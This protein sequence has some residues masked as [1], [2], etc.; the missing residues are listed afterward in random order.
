MDDLRALDFVAKSFAGLLGV[1]GIRVEGGEALPMNVTT[2]LFSAA[3]STVPSALI[4][5]D[6][7]TQLGILAGRV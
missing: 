6:G 4:T 3:E 5:F 7:G 2:K 1:A